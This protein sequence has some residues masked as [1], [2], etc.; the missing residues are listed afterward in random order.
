[1]QSLVEIEYTLN[2]L[3]LTQVTYPRTLNKDMKR[4]YS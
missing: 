2:F 1:M 4:Y 3:P